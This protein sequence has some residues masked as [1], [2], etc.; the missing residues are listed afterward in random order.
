MAE[1]TQEVFETGLDAIKQEHK[2]ALGAAIKELKEGALSK[3]E[4]AVAA[5]NKRIEDIEAS[6]ADIEKQLDAIEVKMKEGGGINVKNMT[7]NDVLTKAI[8][9]NF[10]QIKGVSKKSAIEVNMQGEGEACKA[11]G[12]MFTTNFA[13]TSYANI[14]TDYRQGVLPLPSER[15]WMSD[16]LPSGTTDS[17]VIWYPRHVGGEGA[18]APWADAN[19][20]TS[21]PQLDF[22]FD[23]A[24]DAVQWLAGFVKVPRAMLDDVS[25]LTSFL[26]QNM[27]LSLK[28]T[29][30]YQILNGNGTAPQLKGIIPQADTYNG[31]FAIPVERIIDAGYGQV[32]E[33]Y[34]DANLAMLHPR[35]AVEIA[36]NKASGSGEYDMPPG[37]IGYVNGQLTIAG[38]MVVRTQEIT[39]G[40]FLVGDNKASQ[41]VTR[42]SPRLEVFYEN[43]DDAR[44]NLVMFRIEE[45]AALATFY[46]DWWVKGALVATT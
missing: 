43:E 38:M 32:N 1:I 3:S 7:F 15:I 31:S 35:D 44:K 14:T 20:A 4:A 18:V 11:V 34:G 6:K 36:L 16:V 17:G 24:S 30:N 46:P 23:G 45:R 26:R 8:E 29:E 12:N 42:L 28:R 22:D 19:P 13:G 2:T 25:W 37:T 39:R 10:D 5:A 21:K 9:E 41:F 27:L 33:A 40:Q